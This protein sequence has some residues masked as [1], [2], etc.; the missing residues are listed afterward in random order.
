MFFGFSVRL[1]LDRPPVGWLGTEALRRAAAEVDVQFPHDLPHAA[2]MAT[3][4]WLIDSDG[5]K[6]SRNLILA[7]L[8]KEGMFNISLDFAFVER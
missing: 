4:K 7:K 1:C 6:E 5:Y 3:L 2:T 8:R